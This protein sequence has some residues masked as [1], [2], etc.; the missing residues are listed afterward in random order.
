MTGFR[1]F[2]IGDPEWVRTGVSVRLTERYWNA[3]LS[4]R[5]PGEALNFHRRGGNAAE[6]AGREPEG[7]PQRDAKTEA[8]GMRGRSR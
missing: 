2:R 7:W 3:S 6:I 5:D 8:K 4:G 1:N